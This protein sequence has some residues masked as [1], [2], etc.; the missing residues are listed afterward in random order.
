MPE[1][2]R[3]FGVIAWCARSHPEHQLTERG[4]ALDGTS[5]G[6]AQS[7]EEGTTQLVRQARVEFRV[8]MAAIMHPS[9]RPRNWGGSTKRGWKRKR[10]AFGPRFADGQC[11]T[12]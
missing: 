4:A 5:Q 3:T 12:E 1:K 6:R 10:Y 8:Q 2:N 9:A 7:L 11:S